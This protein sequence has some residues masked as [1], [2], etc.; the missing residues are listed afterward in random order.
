MSKIGLNQL[1]GGQALC[2][3]FGESP[4]FHDAA[5]TTLELRQ[6]ADSVLVAKIFKAGPDVDANGYYVQRDHAVV[7]FTLSE[8]VDVELHDFMQASIMDGLDIE[9]DAGGVT[10]SFDSSYGV[11]GR[12]R[13]KAVR[14][15]FAWSEPGTA[16]AA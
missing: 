13:A 14:L 1:E 15:S 4:T 11:H 7:T 10:L 2:D 16:T 3:W 5:L 6:G 8:L 12:I 9:R